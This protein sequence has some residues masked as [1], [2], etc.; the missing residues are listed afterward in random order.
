MWSAACINIGT[1]GVKCEYL[2]APRGDDQIIGDEKAN[3]D[4]ILGLGPLIEVHA[5]Q[6]EDHAALHAVT[7]GARFGLQQRLGGGA[8]QV[9]GRP[10]LKCGVGAIEM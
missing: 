1:H 9:I 3:R 5:A 2:I 7:V 8:G 10:N 4:H 6:V